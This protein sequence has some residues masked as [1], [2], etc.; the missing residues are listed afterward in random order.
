MFVPVF[1][2]YTLKNFDA[3]GI[4]E[5][6]DASLEYYFKA[7]GLTSFD[8]L[9][10]PIILVDFVVDA[11]SIFAWSMLANINWKVGRLGINSLYTMILVPNVVLALINGYISI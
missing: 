11:I 6:Q 7:E 1:Y 9:I 3:T 5:P 8:Y 4:T 10:T 2:H